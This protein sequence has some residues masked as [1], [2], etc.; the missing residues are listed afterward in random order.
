MTRTVS[1]SVLLAIQILTSKA[2]LSQNP[3]QITAPANGSVV[4]PGDSVVV[5]VQADGSVRPVGVTA[6]PDLGTIE[7]AD[8]PNQFKIQIR[9]NASLGIYKIVAIGR[10]NGEL[11]S[12][13]I[14]VD[15]ERRDDPLK[16]MTDLSYVEFSRIGET[17]PL[18]VRGLY[19]D[20]VRLAVSRSTRITYTSQND[21]V[22][23][24]VHNSVKSV[25]AG[26]TTIT[27]R[28]GIASCRIDVVVP[29]PP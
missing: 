8:N 2:A 1:L 16:L 15:V 17:S 28:L 10:Q 19:S 24:V 26:K 21:Q 9:N 27:V 14:I 7:P 22:A 23:A 12:S 3:I 25:S 18:V 11:I 6:P 20:G 5:I 4:R 13:S 29:S